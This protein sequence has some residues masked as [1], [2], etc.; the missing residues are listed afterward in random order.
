[1]ASKRLVEEKRQSVCEQTLNF[2]QQ[3][4]GILPCLSQSENKI[5]N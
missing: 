2:S 5:E 4:L 1:M 3:F